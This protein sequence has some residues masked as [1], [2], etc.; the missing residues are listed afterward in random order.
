M[1]GVLAAADISTVDHWV[2]HDAITGELAVCC[3]RDS[4]QGKATV[5]MHMSYD[6]YLYVKHPASEGTTIADRS[7]KQ[8]SVLQSA[9]F[10]CAVGPLLFERLCEIR[11]SDKFVTQATKRESVPEWAMVDMAEEASEGLAA[12]SLLLHQRS[13]AA[14]VGLATSNGYVST[15]SCPSSPPSTSPPKRKTAQSPRYPAS[16]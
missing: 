9:D 5:L 8:K 13:L 11:G 4:K 10:A 14:D 12:V 1:L 2:G 7:T 16:I 6:E 3:A 15:H